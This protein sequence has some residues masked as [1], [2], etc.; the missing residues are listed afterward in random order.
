[1]K[2]PSILLL[3]A[4]IIPSLAWGKRIAA[5]VVRPVVLNGVEYSAH[6]D[7]ERAWITATDTTSRKELW[8]A[9]VFRMRNAIR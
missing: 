5:S 3:V 6:G 1:M 2:A 4:A 8:T 7:A 9:K